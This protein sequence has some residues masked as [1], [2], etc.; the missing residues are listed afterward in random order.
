MM[1]HEE[2]LVV[3]FNRLYTAT[4]TNVEG[5]AKS[6]FQ[7]QTV[8]VDSKYYQNAIGC[9]KAMLAQVRKLEATFEKYSPDTALAAFRVQFRTDFANCRSV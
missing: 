9:Y 5:W 4:F 1:K 2:E 3:E 8:S 6:P 7:T